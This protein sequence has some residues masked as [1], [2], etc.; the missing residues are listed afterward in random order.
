MYTKGGP[1]VTTVISVRG[2]DR[3]MLLSD[4]DFIYV[5]R[6]CRQ[7][8]ASPWANPF[9]PGVTHKAA[10]LTLEARIGRVMVPVH[11]FMSEVDA[12]YCL[13]LYKH[14]VMFTELKDRLPELRDR[15]LGCWCCNWDGVSEPAPLCHAVVLANLANALT[16]AP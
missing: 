9:K 14:L 4:M 10:I 13:H 8:P 11:N 2:L 15:R 7:W 12:G 1:L 5:G 6:R 16:E 3:D